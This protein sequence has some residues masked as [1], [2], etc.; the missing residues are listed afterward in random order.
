M[1]DEYEQKPA[2]QRAAFVGLQSAGVGLVFS[3]VQN[4][5]ETHGKGAAGV[6]TRTGSTIGFFA[7]MGAVFSYTE[8]S[9]ANA[10]AT[11]DAWNGAAGGCAAGFLAGI[12]ARSIPTAV[13]S[14]AI[15]GGLVGGFDVTGKS[16]TGGVR[17]F[18][19]PEDREERRLA[20]FKKPRPLST[21]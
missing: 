3:S 21:E 12:R 11:D 16:L 6:L 1:A 10:R 2:L 19:G 18:E 20:F 13:A 14:C 15:L 8:A 4:A 17:D 7:A 9:I 5:L